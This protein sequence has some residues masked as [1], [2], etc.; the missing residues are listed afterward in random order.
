M[1]EHY[2]HTYHLIPRSPQDR[3]YYYAHFMN[4][5]VWDSS[6]LKKKA[7]EDKK[8]EVSFLNNFSGRI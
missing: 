2:T 3:Y 5:Y 7:S 8:F 4:V 1:A 6:K